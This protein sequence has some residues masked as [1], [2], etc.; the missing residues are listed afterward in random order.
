MDYKINMGG[1]TFSESINFGE[2]KFYNLGL[3][4]TA[5]IE[6]SPTRNFDAA[7]ARE[8]PTREQ[9]RRSSWLVIDAGKA[10]H[11]A[12]NDSERK[13]KIQDWNKA[14]NLYPVY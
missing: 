2:L 4:E 12:Q 7:R 1:K 8:K 13:K 11:T 14:M 9:L 6:L 5:E 10:A 3:G